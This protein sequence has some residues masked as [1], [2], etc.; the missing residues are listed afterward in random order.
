MQN[1]LGEAAELHS[2]DQAANNLPGHTGSDGSTPPQRITRAGYNWTAWGENV[3]WNSSNGSA[4]VAFNWWQNST[5][6]N[7]NMLSTNF[8]EIGIGRAQSSSTGYWYWT[9][10]FGDR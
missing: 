9:T 1:Q 5:D 7:N 10:T 3:Y 8:T 4:S 6:H 2:Q